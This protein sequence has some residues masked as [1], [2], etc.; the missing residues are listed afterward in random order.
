MD[1]YAQKIACFLSPYYDE[2]FFKEL[3]LCLKLKLVNATAAVLC[4]Q[5]DSA[6]VCLLVGAQ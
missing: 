3:V 5:F 4:M 1:G 2:G 6:D